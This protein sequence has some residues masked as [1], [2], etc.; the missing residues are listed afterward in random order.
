[1]EARGLVPDHIAPTSDESLLIEVAVEE[2]R[3]VWH[4]YSDGGIALMV[5]LADGTKEFHEPREEE[6]GDFLDGTHASPI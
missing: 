6:F 4:F 3:Q 5:I 1:L 2:E